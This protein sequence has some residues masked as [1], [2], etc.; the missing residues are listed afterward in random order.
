MENNNNKLIV[1]IVL[2][3]ILL[4]V[5]V[6]MNYNLRKENKIIQQE[7]TETINR[8][9]SVIIV[10]VEIEKELQQSTIDLIRF[11]GISSSLDSLLGEAN[12]KIE[13]QKKKIS[14]LAKQAD[15]TKELEKEL[16]EF[17]KLRD[18]YIEKIDSLIQEN[19]LL[20]EEVASQKV[21]IVELQVERESLQKKVDIASIIKSQDIFATCFK[22][23]RG[24]KLAKTVIAKK[25]KKIDVCFTLTE[26]L[27]TE[28]GKKDIFIKIVSPEGVTIT[29]GSS[30]TFTMADSEKEAQY[31]FKETVD[32]EQKVIDQ[33]VTWQQTNPYTPGNYQ[34]ELY[35]NGYLS[36]MGGFILK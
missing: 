3:L 9:D 24:G 14:L 27:I 22:E 28:K 31:T 18:F 17:R 15:K 36:G 2:L 20:Q 32:Y 12:E 25:T 11:K 23:K 5:S 29:D 1:V 30:G 7:K 8:L 10:R 13:K 34:I 6:V 4:I 16:A 21:A 33:C 19:D 26:N 35:Y